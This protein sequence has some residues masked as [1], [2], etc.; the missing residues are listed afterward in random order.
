MEPLD[1]S[2]ALPADLEGLR[3]E[4]IP[5]PSTKDLKAGCLRARAKSMYSAMLSPSACERDTP[6]S[7]PLIVNKL[8][9]LNIINV[10]PAFM[11]AY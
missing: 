10:D 7:K 4:A 11:E 2:S 1:D 3:R 5:F 6:T 9:M 8:S